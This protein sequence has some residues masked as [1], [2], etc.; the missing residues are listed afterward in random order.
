[1]L[2]AGGVQPLLTDANREAL[3]LILDTFPRLCTFIASTKVEMQD[4]NILTTPGLKG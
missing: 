2:S 4:S 1:M 3:T